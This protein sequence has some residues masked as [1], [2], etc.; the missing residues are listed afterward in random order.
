MKNSDLFSNKV[1]DQWDKICHRVEEWGDAGKWV[2]RNVLRRL[3]IEAPVVVCFVF[4]CCLVHVLN[5][6][7]CVKTR[8]KEIFSHFDLYT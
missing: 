5:K 2:S 4:L 6:T 8:L 7:G 1:E 3:S